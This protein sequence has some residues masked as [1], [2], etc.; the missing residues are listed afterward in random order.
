MAH[1]IE[2]GAPGVKRG[3]PGPAGKRELTIDARLAELLI[4]EIIVRRYPPGTPLREQEIADRYG[5][6]R[7]STREALRLMAYAGFVDILPWRGARV[8]DMSFDQF[9]DILGLLEDIYARCATLAAER[10]PETV[11]PQLRATM[12]QLEAALSD[13]ADKALLYRL[14]F[15]F[16]GLIGE[17]CGS[18]IANRLLN[19]VGRLA[20]W[21]Q[22]LRLPGTAESER[23]SLDA[24]RI[25]ASAIQSRQPDIA[26]GAA[27]TIVL[28]TRRTILVEEPPASLRK[29]EAA[30]GIV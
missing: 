17:H 7:P 21:Q 27:R 10:M 4:R 12:A 13:K 29:A 5:V 1:R 11:F 6:S 15:S 2:R 14:S 9:L 19:Q 16:G 18:A 23:Q 26:A 22:R 24:H 28:I 25:L 8:I 3:K 30:S 20:L